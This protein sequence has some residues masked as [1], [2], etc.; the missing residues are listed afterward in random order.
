MEGRP[1]VSSVTGEWKEGLDPAGKNTYAILVRPPAGKGGRPWATEVAE[2]IFTSHLGE[3]ADLFLRK[4]AAYGESGYH[5]E[6]VKGYWPEV[7]RKLARIR[8]A[9][10]LDED[11]S[12]W[13][14]QPNEIIFDLIG[15]LFMM[16]DCWYQDDQ[17]KR[18][19]LAH[20]LADEYE[21]YPAGN[22]SA[23]GRLRQATAA[24]KTV[25]TVRPSA[26][27]NPSSSSIGFVS[28]S[29]SVGSDEP[30]D[31]GWSALPQE[32]RDVLA[33]LNRRV[34]ASSSGEHPLSS[35]TLAAEEAGVLANYVQ[36][37]EE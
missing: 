20:A 7:R 33:A 22:T 31:G 9:V 24:R 13:T 16:Y 36:D 18:A 2:A 1:E 28:G 5:E 19:E 27:Y 17:V 23:I 10:W 8:R 6:G 26:Q 37:H 4:N 15:T 14:E 11:T 3:W 34:N 32:V 30:G 29:I 35:R 12:D 21:G 25:V